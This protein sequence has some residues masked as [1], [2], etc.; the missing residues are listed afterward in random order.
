MQIFRDIHFESVP[1]WFFEISMSSQRSLSMSVYVYVLVVNK[2]QSMLI[3][4]RQVM[5]DKSKAIHRHQELGQKHPTAPQ[6]HEGE[7]VL[8]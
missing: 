5:H 8:S 3:N 1:P 7:R 6:N 2:F 4:I